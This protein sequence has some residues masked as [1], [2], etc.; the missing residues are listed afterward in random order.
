MKNPELGRRLLVGVAKATTLVGLSAVA[1]GC[2][3]SYSEKAQP[4][5]TTVNASPNPST[6]ETPA[7]T[8]E[9]KLFERL[10]ELATQGL[11]EVRNNFAQKKELTVIKGMCVAWKSGSRYIVTLNPAFYLYETPAERFSF[12]IFSRGTDSAHIGPSIDD[13]ILMN[14]ASEYAQ[15]NPDGSMIPDTHYAHEYDTYV[16]DSGIGQIKRNTIIVKPSLVQQPSGEY[17]AVDSTTNEPVAYTIGYE[18]KDVQ[19]L[20][21]LCKQMGFHGGLRLPD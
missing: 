12:L 16:G 9:E 17:S 14:G 11:T 5:T 20:P 4:T 7:T 6:T 13:L 3:G 21:D 1:L 15:K 18:G 19:D 10:D 2:T 8:P